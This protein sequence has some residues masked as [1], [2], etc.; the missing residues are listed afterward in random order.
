MS[1]MTER[2]E[3]TPRVKLTY[4]DY[5]LSP[6][7]GLR[8]EVID[9]EHYVS[10]SSNTRHQRILLRLAGAL[11]N[12]LGAHPVGEVFVAPFDVVFTRHDV[13]AADLVYLS[14]FRAAPAERSPCNRTRPGRRDRVS[15]HRQARP[16]VEAAPLRTRRCRRVLVRGT[17]G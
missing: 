17:A 10:A 7:D 9:G 12:W 14:T 1:G 6:E 5:V 15:E 8:H 11:W 13:V 3:S 4:D 16:H 2:E